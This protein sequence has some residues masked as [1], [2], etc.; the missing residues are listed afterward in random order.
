MIAERTRRA[1]SSRALTANVSGCL[2]LRSSVDFVVAGD[3]K[4][5]I[6]L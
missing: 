6:D 5:F 2:L 1:R 4:V 3:E